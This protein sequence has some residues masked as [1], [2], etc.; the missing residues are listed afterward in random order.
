MGWLC[1][2]L[3]DRPSVWVWLEIP[4]CLAKPILRAYIQKPGKWH[5]GQQANRGGEHSTSRKDTFG[6]RFPLALQCLPALVL[7]LGSP[8]LP[9]S[10]RWLI[11]K[12]KLYPKTRK[13]AWWPTS[14]PRRRALDISER[15]IG[16]TVTRP[17]V[18]V[19]LEIPSCLAM[20]ARFGSASGISLAP[21]FT[22]LVK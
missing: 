8:W 3:C 14:Q 11:S 15:Y 13:M 1:L 9:R 22:S 16:Q 18:W 12:G 2:L 10:P 17:S 6:W 4:S 21:A 19:W 20:P 5:G 7:L